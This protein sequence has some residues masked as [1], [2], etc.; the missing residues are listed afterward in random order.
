MQL[1]GFLSKD[2]DRVLVSV[3]PMAG[4]KDATRRVARLVDLLAPAGLTVEVHSDLATVAQ[5]ANRW[6]EEGKLRSL[7]GVGGDG[8]AAELVNRTDVGV[9]LIMLSSGTENLLARHLGLPAEAEDVCRTIVDGHFIRLDVGRANG[10]LFL[11]MVG[12]GFDAEV[13][14]RLHQSRR[15]HI[16]RLSYLKPILSAMRSYGYPELRVYW[17]DVVEG[18]PPKESCQGASG[19]GTSYADSRWAFVFNLPRYGGGF[20]IAPWAIGNDGLLDV[21]TFR[22]GRLWHGLRFVAGVLAGRHRRMSDCTVGKVRR[23]RITAEQPVPYQLD[24]DPGGYLPLEI[25][26]LPGR[27]TVV[28]PA[29]RAEK[30][31][32]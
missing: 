21:C 30:E 19:S 12:C 31:R 24:G 14:R 20:R 8:T 11:L 5:R 28:V 22:R 16:R 4:C 23:L 2:A 26:V 7:V 29:D 13:V 1:D 32:R 15:G 17:E 25:D 10:R 3:N 6:H 18:G 27:L 9:P